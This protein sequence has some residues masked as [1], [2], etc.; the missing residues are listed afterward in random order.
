MA[1]TSYQIKNGHV[2][3]YNDKGNYVKSI[4]AKDVKAVSIGSKGN[5]D[6]HREN[7]RETYKNNLDYKNYYR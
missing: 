1:I 6:I 4:Q 5:I 2:A 7:V 3:F